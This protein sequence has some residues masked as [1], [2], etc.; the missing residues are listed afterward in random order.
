MKAQGTQ[1]WEAL[2]KRAPRD[3]FHDTFDQ[4]ELDPETTPEE[5][6]IFV[7][8]AADM[9]ALFSEVPQWGVAYIASVIVAM[10]QASVPAD[11]QAEVKETIREVVLETLG[12]IGIVE[13]MKK[14]QGPA[15]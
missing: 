10:V 9:M 13:M 3:A 14:T 15:S 5:R 6:K 8:T 4:M 7:D 2:M 12:Q 1:N 11:K